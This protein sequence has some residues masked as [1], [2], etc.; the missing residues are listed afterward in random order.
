[1]PLKLI[2]T[3]VVLDATSKNAI[4][5]YARISDTFCLDYFENVEAV[6]GN[7]IASGTRTVSCASLFKGKTR[8]GTV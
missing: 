1:M 5:S 2:L 6:N 3:F 7:S 4:A 8:R